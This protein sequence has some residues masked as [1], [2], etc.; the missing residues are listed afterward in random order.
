MSSVSRGPSLAGRVSVP[1]LP[2]ALGMGHLPRA[3]AVSPLPQASF[4]LG[5]DS[6]SRHPSS[7]A[8]LVPGDVAHH[9]LEGAA[10]VSH[11]LLTFGVNP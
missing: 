2:R 11:G 7:S 3:L 4:G 9:Q 6:V 8:H 1:E 5:G 10:G